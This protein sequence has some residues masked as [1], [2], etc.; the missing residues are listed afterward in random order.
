MENFS[1]YIVEDEE[2]IALALKEY[3]ESI[4]FKVYVEEGFKNVLSNVLSAN[5]SLVLLDIQLP[6]HSGFHW[7][8]EIRKSSN[9][10]IV[11]LSGRNDNLNIISAIELGGDDFIEKPFDL[12]VLGAKIHSLL[13]RSYIMRGGSEAFIYGS[14]KLKPAEAKLFFNEAELDLSKT[15]LQILAVLFENA[16]NFV[17][18]DTM[19]LRLWNTD[20]FI[21]DNTLS[22][23][24]ARLRKK[25]RSLCEDEIIISRKL[26]G[27]KLQKL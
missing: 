5:P 10:P 13:R 26:V 14:L 12:S 4:G 9:V 18:R 11:F 2:S 23:N 22:V 8:S 20:S 6:Y 25:L 1:I 17:S 16:G 21:D 19:M 24:I 3:F 27:Y 7:C 15:E